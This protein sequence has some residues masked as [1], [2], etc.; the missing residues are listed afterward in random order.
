MSDIG[1]RVEGLAT[2]SRTMRKAGED[3]TE[4]KDAH[5]RAG[6]IVADRAAA[7]RAPP[8]GRAGRARSG[9]RN[10]PRRARVMAGSGRSDVRRRRSIGG[11]PSA[12]S[13]RSRS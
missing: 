4:L 7:A 10:K 1:I 9:Q 6:Q 11:G 2:L 3:L 5:T 8:V 13:R 12:T